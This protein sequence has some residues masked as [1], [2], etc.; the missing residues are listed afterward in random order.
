MLDRQFDEVD[1]DYLCGLPESGFRESI[2]LEFKSEISHRDRLLKEVCAFA[3]TIGGDLLIGVKDEDGFPIAVPGVQY[4]GLAIDQYE[5]RISQ[6]ILSDIEPPVPFQIRC[7]LL[8]DG[9]VLTRI[10]VDQSFIGPHRLVRTHKFYERV[11]SSSREMSMDTLRQSFGVIAM[12]EE[13]AVQHHQKRISDNPYMVPDPE[14]SIVF[15][16]LIPVLSLRRQVAIPVA[17]LPQQQLVMPPVGNYTTSRIDHLGHMLV[18]EGSRENNLSHVGRDGIIEGAMEIAPQP[19]GD[20]A[21]TRYWTRTEDHYVVDFVER[22]LR[23]L[24]E[25]GV[26]GPAFICVSITN[27][28]GLRGYRDRRYFRDKLVFRGQQLCCD[29]VFIES[30]AQRAS[31]IMRV[32]LD[33]IWNGFGAQRCPSYDEE[34]RWV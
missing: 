22:S 20:D 32:P 12:L 13:R 25:H 33:I 7:H 28:D 2:T 27:A 4:E 29:P 31:E 14:K 24:E 5:L 10:R 8:E 21:G 23:F 26:V 3:N 34:G 15:V 9:S 30:L 19:L 6:Q 1:I 17:M 18:S 11:S 16:H